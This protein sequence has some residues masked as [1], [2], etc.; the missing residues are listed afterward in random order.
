MTLKEINSEKLLFDIH[1]KDLQEQ[2][3]K[4]FPEF[5]LYEGKVDSTKVIQYI[6][7]LADMQSPMRIEQPDYYA[8]KYTIAHMVK[9]PM[10]KK[11]FTPE[12]E[13]ILIGEDDAV[14][15]TIVNYISSYGMPN[16]SLL[17]AFTALM[18]FET[19]KIFAGKGT[20]D[21][22][23]TID[24]ASD[25]IQSLTRDFFK[26]GD[27]DEYSKVKQI[28]YAKVEKDKVRLRPEQLVRTLAESGYLPNDFS[29]FG[30]DYVISLKDDLLF[31]GDK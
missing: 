22:Q 13:S 18:S 30:S 21:S 4:R 27:Y 20:K 11:E 15:N 14:N 24:N 31:L 29:P 3:T 23:K 25:R 26:S 12:S 19:Q 16:Y 1:A 17:M 6:I 10:S 28:L 2:F 5:G 9:F 7:L 8:R